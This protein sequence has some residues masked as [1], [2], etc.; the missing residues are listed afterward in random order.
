[1][2]PRVGLASLPIICWLG[3]GSG[4]ALGNPRKGHLKPSKVYLFL[5]ALGFRRGAREMGF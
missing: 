3:F 5:T 2:H 4:L 1:M